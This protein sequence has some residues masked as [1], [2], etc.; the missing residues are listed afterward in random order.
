MSITLVQRELFS[1]QA[2]YTSGSPGSLGTVT[3]TFYRRDR[4]PRTS[5]TTGF[6]GEIRGVDAYHDI[7]L[8]GASATRLFFGAWYKVKSFASDGSNGIRL[9]TAMDSLSS[10]ANMVTS[11]K[12]V[13]T[14]T[15][16][17]VLEGYPST[18]Q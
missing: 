5:G 17:L 12:V 8:S 7:A 16:F 6:S 2:T 15:R 4:G 3:G 10:G 18:T 1:G 9:I 11:C 14:T 13:S